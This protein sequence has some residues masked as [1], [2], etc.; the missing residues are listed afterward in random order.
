MPDFRTVHDALN[1]ARTE[2]TASAAST[3]ESLNRIN[4]GLKQTRGV[5]QQTIQDNTDTARDA[6]IVAKEAA[7][8]S[9]TAAGSDTVD[10]RC[11]SSQLEDVG[12][13]CICK[14]LSSHFQCTPQ[15]QTWV[16]D[17]IVLHI[18]KNTARLL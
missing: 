18:S 12:F 16:P 4:A 17:D 10:L 5:I 8:A 11:D 2:A 1:L 9:K 13:T 15:V 14:L 6:K 7:E 3:T